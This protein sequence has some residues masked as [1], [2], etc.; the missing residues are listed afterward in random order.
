M[1]SKSDTEHLLY[2]LQ[3]GQVL[4]TR[5]HEHFEQ[6]HR[7]VIGSGGHHSG[8]HDGSLRKGPKQKD[9]ARCDRIGYSK[10]AVG[11]SANSR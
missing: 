7:L 2:A 9:E 11:R 5:N 4:L 8:Y 3:Q 1:G 6:L 10:A